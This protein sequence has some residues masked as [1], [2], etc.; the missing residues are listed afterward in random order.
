M[1]SVPYANC[2]NGWKFVLKIEIHESLSNWYLFIN[3]SKQLNIQISPATSPLQIALQD[4]A[5]YVWRVPHKTYCRSKNSQFK[6]H[7][8]SKEN[9]ESK[10]DPINRPT[11][12]YVFVVFVLNV[13]KRQ[14]AK[15]TY[16][17][18]ALYIFN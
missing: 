10:I 13:D 2:T 9:G 6:Q 8:Q 15:C 3:T 7:L 17:E 1:Y 4:K 16:N 12:V 11:S 5:A 18:K 14:S